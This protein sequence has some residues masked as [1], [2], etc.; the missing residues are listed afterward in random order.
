MITYSESMIKLW[1]K[2]GSRA[3]FGS[4]AAPELAETNDKVLFLAADVAS[5]AGFGRFRELWPDKLINA[6]IAEQNMIGIASGM[7]K[8]GFIPFAFS[9]TPFISLRT[10]DQIRLC[11]GYMRLPVKII[12]LAS[13]LSM[14]IN[15]ASHL[16]V[17]DV[18]FM[19]AV[20]GITILS[21]ADATET[22]KT[23][24]AAAEHPGPVYIRLTGELNNPP[25]YKED[26][27]FAIGKAITMREGKDVTFLATG[28][29]VHTSLA[30]AELLSAEGIDAGVINM[31]TLRPLDMD[32]VRSA[33]TAKLI[34]SVEE[35]SIVGG[36]GG[37][38]AEVLAETGSHPPLLR[39]GLEDYPHAD[40][41]KNL[42][43]QCGLTSE[44]I[45]QRV[46]I[47]FNNL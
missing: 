20:P 33:C 19:R 14:G 12:A 30:A 18:A 4:V 40:T 17:E 32:A 15:G 7:A 21:P 23:I 2:L 44:Q 47:R 5:S 34:V 36:L 42:L 3:V 24:L 27:E 1:S 41:Y 46:R 37:G 31:H 29:M 8:E 9:F 35:H 39:L 10:A 26:Y 13:G 11:L 28:S 45:A 22:I 6:G 16:G 25:V 38:V 43:N